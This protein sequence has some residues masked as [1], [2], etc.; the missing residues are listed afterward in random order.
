MELMYKD[1]N[2][3]YFDIINKTLNEYSPMGPYERRFLPDIKIE[4]YLKDFND[5]YLIKGARPYQ[6]AKRRF[7][8]KPFVSKM[9][10]Q[11]KYIKEF[12]KVDKAIEMNRTY[13]NNNIIFSNK[14]LTKN[15]NNLIK[16]R[17]YYKN[18]EKGQ[19]FNQI[20]NNKLIFNGD[21]KGNNSNEEIIKS[22]ND[23]KERNI[24]ENEGLSSSNEN[25][26]NYTKNE[27]KKIAKS[28]GGEKF[29][30]IEKRDFDNEGNL[31]Q[32]NKFEQENQTNEKSTGKDEYEEDLESK[33]GKR[34]NI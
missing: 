33:G 29:G 20:Y 10:K 21:I 6:G 24:F 13:Y 5:P 4:K 16:E 11:I 31:L 3:T 18:I 26:E 34:K 28:V 7:S 14:N 2:V 25:G 22:I 27:E 12:E 9:E 19:D 30:L 23:D 32:I 8:F 15:D 17:K 1:L